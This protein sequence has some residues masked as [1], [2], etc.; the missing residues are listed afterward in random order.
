MTANITND[1]ISASP[2]RRRFLKT[3]G[4]ATAAAGAFF[5][6]LYLRYEDCSSL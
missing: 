2:N 6:A 1:L 5:D 4:V 3:V